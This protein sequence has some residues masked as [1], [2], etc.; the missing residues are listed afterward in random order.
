MSVKINEGAPAFVLEIAKQVKWQLQW[1][2]WEEGALTAGNLW[3]KTNA[4][5]IFAGTIADGEWPNP[6]KT[7]T[8]A[9][10]AVTGTLAT[11]AIGSLDPTVTD[12][13]PSSRAWPTTLG[14]IKYFPSKT[15]PFAETGYVTLDYNE[16]KASYDNYNTLKTT[17]E[18]SKTSYD[19][20]RVAYNLAITNEN[21]RN[22]DFFRQ[23]FESPITIPTRPCKPDLILD[24]V[25]LTWKPD[26]TTTAVLAW[27]AA[28][29][30]AMW[31]TFTMNTSL[32]TVAT[33]YRVGYQLVTADTAGT[34]VAN[35][36]HVYGLLG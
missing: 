10:T 8:V 28:N 36:G 15:G 9:G 12:Y 24:Y 7:W 13:D 27:T 31:A 2:E 29:K 19:I 23:V 1:A 26:V 30:A 25:G 32:Q 20:L 6:I 3:D 14:D 11:L 34:T 17:F 18:T 21:L 22:A 33:S 35:A 4:T 16:M 5:P